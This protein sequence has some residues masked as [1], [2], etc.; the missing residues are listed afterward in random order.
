MIKLHDGPPTPD[1]D[2]LPKGTIGN[3]KQLTSARS[4]YTI[5]TVPAL[6]NF[7]HITLGAPPISTWIKAIKQGWFA[8]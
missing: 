8:S 1:T 4:A 6:I 5:K 7:Y 3:P 2:A